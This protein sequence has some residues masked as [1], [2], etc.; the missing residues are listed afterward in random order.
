MF[1]FTLYLYRPCSKG[2]S[3]KPSKNQA[4]GRKARVDQWLYKHIQNSLGKTGNTRA[5][6]I[7]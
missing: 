7:F 1:L 2:Y 4:I 6:K 5:E 3:A